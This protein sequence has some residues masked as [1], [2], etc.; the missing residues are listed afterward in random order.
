MG[1]ESFDVT[2]RFV[3]GYGWL[4]ILSRNG[5]EQ[6]R[7]EFQTEPLAALERGLAMAS[8]VLGVLIP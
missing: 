8:R 6:A 5:S 7:G 2:L 3:P 1:P 4:Y